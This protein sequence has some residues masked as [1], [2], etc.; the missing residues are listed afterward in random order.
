MQRSYEV[1]LYTGLD[2]GRAGRPRKMLPPPGF[3]RILLYSAPHRYLFLCLDCLAFCLLSLLTTHNTS[4]PPVGYTPSI[5]A[6]PLER[7]ADHGFDPRTV[8]PAASDYTDCSIP[9]S[10]KFTPNS[11][12]YINHT[13]PRHVTT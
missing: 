1:P 13:L 12:A 7:G 11:V 10:L 6:R 4:M 5:P 2:D 8:Q 3:F 9:A